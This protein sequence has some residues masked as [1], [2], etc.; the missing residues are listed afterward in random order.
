MVGERAVAAAKTATCVLPAVRTVSKLP[1]AY[2]SALHV[3]KLAFKGLTPT[4]KINA[5]VLDQQ[6]IYLHPLKTELTVSCLISC[7]H[8]RYA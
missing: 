2:C 7:L 4:L 1:L 8:F 3:I 6:K 5:N